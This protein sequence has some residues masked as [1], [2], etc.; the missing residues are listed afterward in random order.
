M[1]RH[2]QAVRDR[3]GL[4]GSLEHVA[5]L[6]RG[7]DSRLGAGHPAALGVLGGRNLQDCLGGACDPCLSRAHLLAGFA[8]DAAQPAT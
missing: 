4:L 7:L 3:C 6:A 1:H 2:L 5:S 8:D